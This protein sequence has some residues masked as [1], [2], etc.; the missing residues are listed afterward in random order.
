MKNATEFAQELVMEHFTWD[1]YRIE[2]L[3]HS[4]I[5]DEL[6]KFLKF[7][8][9]DYAEHVEYGG[10]IV[11]FR[12]LRGEDSVT[13]QEIFVKFGDC[14]YFTLEGNMTLAESALYRT[15]RQ[16]QEEQRGL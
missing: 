3:Q 4:M 8:K 1:F 10:S 11:I 5:H 7:H 14:D 13:R 9:L 2:L 15:Y 16:I 12:A 6:I